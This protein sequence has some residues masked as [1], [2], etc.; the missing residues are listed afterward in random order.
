MMLHAQSLGCSKQIL[1]IYCTLK[2]SV[3]SFDLVSSLPLHWGSL[4]ALWA[5]CQMTRDLRPATVSR[6]SWQ[7]RNTKWANICILG[8]IR[9]FMVIQILIQL[10]YCNIVCISFL[11]TWLAC[12]LT[13]SLRALYKME[14]PVMKWLSVSFGVLFTSDSGAFQGCQRLIPVTQTSKR[15]QTFRLIARP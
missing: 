3:F 1:M 5:V 13:C 6:S 11:Y 4:H 7:I 10:I 9:C 15:R 2:I 12:S 14:L 8:Y